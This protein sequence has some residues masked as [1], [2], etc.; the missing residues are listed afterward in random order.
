MD[1]SRR[2]EVGGNR[3]VPD[4][5]LLKSFNESELYCIYVDPDSCVVDRICAEWM[6]RLG[7][8]GIKSLSAIFNV[9]IISSRCRSVI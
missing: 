6:L 2:K 8:K 4:C 1:E 7:G 3:L 5:D 9:L